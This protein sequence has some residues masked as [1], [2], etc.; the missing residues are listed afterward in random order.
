MA[1]EF[2]VVWLDD[3]NSVVTH[4]RTLAEAFK[5]ASDFGYIQLYRQGTARAPPGRAE[6][7]E[8]PQMRYLGQSYLILRLMFACPQPHRS[9]SRSPFI[10][11]THR[12]SEHTA[13]G[14]CMVLRNA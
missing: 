8:Q 1:D 12:N 6:Q 9:A 14:H 4:H 11:V 7:D 13:F 10:G 3:G 2:L 5:R